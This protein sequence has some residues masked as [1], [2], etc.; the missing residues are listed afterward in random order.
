MTATDLVD[1]YFAHMRGRDL[2]GLAGLFAEDATAVFPDGREVAGLAAISAMYQHIFNAGAP[3]PTP[4]STI[5]GPGGAAV[6][7]EARLPDGTSRR[8]ANF[9][10]LGPDGRIVQLSVYKRGNW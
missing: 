5:A 3:T 8:T 10:H 6:E 7:I 9:F 1:R 2:E 4:L